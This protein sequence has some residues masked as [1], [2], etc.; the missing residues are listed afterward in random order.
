MAKGNEDDEKDEDDDSA[1]TRRKA[2]VY[3][4]SLASAVINVN[5]PAP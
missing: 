5:S 3:H 4:E 2:D 1:L